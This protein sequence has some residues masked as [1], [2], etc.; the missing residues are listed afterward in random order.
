V[1]GAGTL[2]SGSLN[3]DA[4]VVGLGLI[5]KLPTLFTPPTILIESALIEPLP[6]A[7]SAD[8]ELEST[9]MPQ[10]VRFTFAEPVMEK[11]PL[12]DGSSA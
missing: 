10:V 8:E 5:E 12:A 11:A 6:T 9:A 4:P 1:A 3:E 2:A 7:L